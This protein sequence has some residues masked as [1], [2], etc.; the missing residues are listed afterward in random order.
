VVK[1]LAPVS[2]AHSVRH[3]PLKSPQPNQ[4][5]MDGPSE[6]VLRPT[7]KD[8]C[9]CSHIAG[10]NGSRLSGTLPQRSTSSRTDWMTGAICD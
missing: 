4:L 9:R 10:V 3:N 1:Q 2:W 5:Q 7:A 8:E 6:K